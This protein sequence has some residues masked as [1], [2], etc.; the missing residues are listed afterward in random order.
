MISMNTGNNHSNITVLANNL[1]I[2]T[3][4]DIINQVAY[5]EKNKNMEQY[6]AGELIQYDNHKKLGY[7][8]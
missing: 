7:I 6:F 5:L 8:I 1:R 3:E 4:S 2:K